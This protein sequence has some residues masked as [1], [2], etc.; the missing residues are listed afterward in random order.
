MRVI[1]LIFADLVR[2]ALVAR[3]RLAEPMAG[4][5]VLR[6]T[7]DRLRQSRELS[8]IR[9]V[10]PPA[11]REAVHGLLAG[12]EAGVVA[13]EWGDPP[14]RALVR[15]GRLWAPQAWRGGVGG[16]CWFD[17]E[18]NVTAA[19]TIARR[20]Q[21]AA[22]A[23]VPAGA[24]LIAPE[25][26]DAMIR[27]HRL[28]AETERL[29]F[30]Q[31]PP[32]LSPAIFA[33]DLLA[34][35]QPGGHP[36]GAM[37]VYRPDYPIADLTGKETCY[38]PA[39]AIIE[40]SGRL[41]AD[42]THGFALVA[43]AIEAGAE[44]W[45][46]E[47]LAAWM[48]RPGAAARWPEEIEIELTTHDP[49]VGGVRLR[50]REPEVPPRG[51]LD[52]ARLER[53]CNDFGATDDLR[54]VLGGF[55]EPTAHPRFADALRALR[56]SGAAALALATHGHFDAAIDDLLFSLPL[57]LLLVRL[58]AATA[59]TYARV[60]G[61]AG[62]AA[63]IERVERWAQRREAQRTVRPMLCPEFLKTRENVADMEAFYDGWLRRLGVAVIAGPSHFGGRRADL[64]V[65][66]VT[67][68]RRR[69]CRRIM[70]RLLVLADG[71][72][73]ACDQD[74]G[75]AQVVGDLA[76]NSLGDV[77]NGA[78]M[79]ALREDHAAGRWDAH[80]LCEGCEEW[81]RP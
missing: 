47:E 36:P 38:R 32:G 13:D 35:L 25:L 72:F 63:A 10:C 2:G 31:A 53:L 1:G 62:Y 21:A 23:C 18:L 34:E 43:D 70:T 68:P 75:A 19:A 74:Y 57:D 44:R 15:A 30:S 17:E 58:D 28:H 9:V 73:V 24:A 69:A 61:H 77:W 80:P 41:I 55:G 11:Q 76:T 26:C 67:P 39:A 49:H 33:A 81:H 66:R 79:R 65:T 16:L 59:E 14:Y 71:R 45:S 6:R 51:P 54:V 3:S 29:T 5:A 56:A 42:T 8:G 12:L 40:C 50:P 4:T 46:A 37:L 7:V 64:C 52:L 27:H 22:V 20:E 60:H 78:R 48:S